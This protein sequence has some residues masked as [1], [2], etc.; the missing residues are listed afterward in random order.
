ML[1]TKKHLKSLMIF[2]AGSVSFSAYSDELTGLYIAADVQNEEAYKSW[3]KDA[4]KV[5]KAHGC[6]VFRKGTIAKGKEFGNLEWKKASSFS[7][8]DC[9]KPV[10]FDLINT[11]LYDTFSSVTKN[12]R[13]IEGKLSRMPNNNPGKRSEYFTKVTYFNG[14]NTGERNAELMTLGKMAGSRNGTWVNDGV[15]VPTSAVGIVR[16][17]ELVFIYYAEQGQG[18][19]F[20]NENPDIMKM[21]GSFNKKHVTKFTYIPSSIEG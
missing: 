4:G 10:L 12:A 6:K 8:F 2:I 14:L 16:P 17:D 15:L 19:K 1:L 3:E 21:I 9:E 13:I 7:V 5:L 18:E 11:G 20:R